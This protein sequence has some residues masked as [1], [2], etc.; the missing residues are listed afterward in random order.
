[1]TT[2]A[3]GLVVIGDSVRVAGEIDLGGIGAADGVIVVPG[4]PD[5]D[6]TQDELDAVAADVAALDARVSAQETRPRDYEH[7][8]G[9]ASAVWQVQHHLGFKPTFVA[10]DLEGREIR[11]GGITH[12]VPG[13]ISE[14]A[15][16]APFAGSGYAS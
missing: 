6:V 15:F 1:M 10:Y 4:A 12:P 5:G 16:G 3:G 11:H 8:Q 7:T 13:E 2:A 14:V 9:A